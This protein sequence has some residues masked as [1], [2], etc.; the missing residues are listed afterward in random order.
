[1]PILPELSLEAAIN[2]LYAIYYF[3]RQAITS[4]LE[5]TLFQAEPEIATLYGDATTMLVG[6]TAIYL[7][8]EFFTAA[9]R[10]VKMILVLGW[11]LL[12]ISIL[13]GKV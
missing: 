8:L 13:V 11:I 7:V 12:I 3:L 6:L 2:V 5:A 1:M 4:I 10:I 9:K